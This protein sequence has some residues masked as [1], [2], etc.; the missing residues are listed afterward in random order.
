MFFRDKHC[1]RCAGS[2]TQEFRPLTPKELEAIKADRGDLWR[3]TGEGCR[4]YQPWH[5]QRDGGLLPEELKIQAAAT[6]PA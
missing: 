2:G 4:W 5:K 3:C 1:P 6:E